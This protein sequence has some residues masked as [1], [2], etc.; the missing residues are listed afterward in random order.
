MRDSLE[1]SARSHARPRTLFS[2]VWKPWVRRPSRFGDLAV[3][4]FFVVQVLDGVF[5]Y[6]GI[7][8]YGSAV[9]ANPVVA[10]M[11]QTFGDARGLMT[12]KLAA[13][14][15][16]AALHLYRVHG[17]VAVLTALY[18]AAAILPWAA[19]LFL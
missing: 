10:S 1:H 5:T 9:E 19:L 8:T 16:G 14:T 12:A 4:A 3:V 2:L 15:L 6:L 17:L 18:L 11:M 7:L 13:A